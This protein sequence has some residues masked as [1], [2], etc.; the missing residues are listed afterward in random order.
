MPRLAFLTVI[1]Q[2]PTFLYAS[3]GAG[4][5]ILLEFLPVRGIVSSSSCS[6]KK[7]GDPS[8]P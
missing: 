8:L 2:M 6:L 1:N 5:V 7:Y 4:A 3:L